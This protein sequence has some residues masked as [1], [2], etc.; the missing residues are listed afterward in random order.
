MINTL[1]LNTNKN[2]TLTITPTDLKFQ[3]E[4]LSYRVVL[5]AFLSDTAPHPILLNI[6]SGYSSTQLLTRTHQVRRTTG[7]LPARYD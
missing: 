5:G 3:G 6:T 1:P 2:I 4:K 7:H